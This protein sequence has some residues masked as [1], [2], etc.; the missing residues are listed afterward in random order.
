MLISAIMPT[1]DRRA[2]FAVAVQSFLSQDWEEKEL[3]VVDDGVDCV[4]DVAKH[5]SITYVRRPGKMTIGAK[6][7][8]ACEIA[9]GDVLVRWDDDDWS[10][11][12]RIFDQMRRMERTGKSISGYHSML[13]WDDSKQRA[14]KYMGAR[15]YA[16]GTSLCFTRK[17]WEQEKFADTSRDEDNRFIRAARRNNDIASGEAGCM[18][19]A[20]IHP[21]NTSPKDSLDGVVDT[22]MIPKEFFE[23]IR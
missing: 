1:A 16:L 13:F 5:P 22:G 2:M 11:P 21:N 18:L 23:A 15:N 3:I 19:V 14:V 9:R 12:G 8:L 20:R 17:Y 6:L 10:G 7:N 4:S